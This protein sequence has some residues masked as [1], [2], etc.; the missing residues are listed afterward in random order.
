RKRQAGDGEPR[1]RARGEIW[2][3]VS[4]SAWSVEGRPVEGCVRRER[5]RRAGARR[6]RR[7]AVRDC[8]SDRRRGGP[9]S[10]RRGDLP[11]EY[12]SCNHLSDRADCQ[13]Q[14]RRK[15]VHGLAGQ[16]RGARDLQEV[17]LLMIAL[18]AEEQEVL[19]LSLRVA[20][21]SVVVSLPF[22]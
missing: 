16:A 5:A 7:G 12:P 13:R 15:G 11:R 6:A 18:G 17:R 10:A 21:W 22:A 4:G 8:V 9:E 19:W 20:F 3:G 14:A 2:Q 1:R